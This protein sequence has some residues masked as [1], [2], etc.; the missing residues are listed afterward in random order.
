MPETSVARGRAGVGK[1]PKKGF[2]LQSS[3]KFE[4]STGL[5]I[6]RVIFKFLKRLIELDG[7]VLFIYINKIE[8]QRYAPTRH[9]VR[10]YKA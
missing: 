7:G 1:T 4:L 10:S 8:T 6:K 2:H 5:D 9:K 3:R